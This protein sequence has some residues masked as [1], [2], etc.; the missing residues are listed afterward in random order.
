MGLLSFWS[1][2]VTPQTIDRDVDRGGLCASQ[3][4]GHDVGEPTI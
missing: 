1:C 4:V 2:P 3:R